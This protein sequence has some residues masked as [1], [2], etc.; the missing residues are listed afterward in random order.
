MNISVS[1]IIITHNR[2]KLLIKAIDSVLYQKFIDFE[3]L[4]IDDASTDETEEVVLK[5]LVDKRVKYIKKNKSN[6]IAQVRNS[7]W[8]YV[9]GEY[10]A[11]LDSDDIWCDELKLKKQYDFLETY[12]DVVLVGGGAILINE[13][14]EETN[15]VINPISDTEIRK[16]FLIKNPFYHSSAMYRYGLINKIGGYNE[17]IKYGEDLDLWLRMG[18]VGKLYNFPEFFI[19]Y[20]IHNDNEVSKHF[21]KAIVDV[22]RVI[23]KNRKGYG[24]GWSIYCR[25][26]LQKFLEY[27]KK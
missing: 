22:L 3:L 17:N 21:G 16:D 10:I 18:K 24:I 19:K 7:A 1:V 15:R 9:S 25:K 27:F 2:S 11:I 8:Q 12:S 14:E 4:I 13:K 20:R 5:Y 23:S 6:S 26:I